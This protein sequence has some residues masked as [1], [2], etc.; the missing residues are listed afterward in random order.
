M[1]PVRVGDVMSRRVETL[2]EWE[3]CRVDSL[4]RRFRQFHHLP[5]LDR[6]RRVVGVVTPADALYTSMQSRSVRVR[7]VMTAPAVTI[8]EHEPI[9]VAAKQMIEERIHSLPVVGASGELVGIVTGTDLL[10][11]LAGAHKV[12]ARPADMSVDTVMT[13]GPLTLGSDATIADAAAL[14]ADAGVRHLPI[15]DPGGTLLGIVSDRDLREQLRG[16]I[17]RWPEAPPD[18]L[19]EPLSSVMTPNPVA[20]RSG[21]SI[22]G[23][24]EG[25]TDERVSALPVVDDQDHLLGIVSYVDLLDWIRREE[26]ERREREAPSGEA[27][28]GSPP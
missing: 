17:A 24:L 8:G 26:E 23:A 16:D 15:V 10:R 21:T 22:R 5:V 6:D 27:E 18:R 25:F 7:E 19:D 12:P 1:E 9:E 2:S 11:A 3:E 13:H 14:M 4:L 28:L 20:L